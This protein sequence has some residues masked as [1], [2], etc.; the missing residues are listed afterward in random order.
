MRIYVIIKKLSVGKLLMKNYNVDVYVMHNSFIS[1]KR[2][3][4]Y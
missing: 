4:L 1:P 3:L 2:I